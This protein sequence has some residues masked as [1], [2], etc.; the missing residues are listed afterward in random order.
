MR[1]SS[2][3]VAA[4]FGAVSAFRAVT[5]MRMFT[6]LFSE[7]STDEPHQVF[8]GN[9]PFDVS[10]ESLESIVQE[11]TKTFKSIRLIINKENGLSRGFAF[12]DYDS[13]EEADAASAALAGLQINGRSAKVDSIG[14]KADK[15]A[16]EKRERREPAARSTPQ[17]QSQH[18]VFVGNLDFSVTEEELSALVARE[19]GE[20][21][22]QAVRINKDRET[23][24]SRGFAHLD[25]TDA[26]AAS[27]VVSKL[28]GMVVADRPLKTDFA[29]KSAP[30]RRD[31]SRARPA[32]GGPSSSVFVAN[33]AWDVTPELIEEM[34][35][36]VVGPDVFQRVRLATDRETGRL[37]GFGHIDL[38]S[39]EAAQRAVRELDG[40]EVLGR[41]IRAD[42]A[43]SAEKSS[44]PRDGGARGGRGGGSR[45]GGRY[46]N[47]REESGSFGS[48]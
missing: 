23:G 36:D 1:F 3:L 46:E 20:G 22:V 40:M 32:P 15:P 28:A 31:Q 39:M 33:L 12:L 16:A 34:V 27:E 18:S 10:K 29:E 47:N 41:Q 48:W 30:V 35:N 9:L 8:I 37:R 45:G 25:C 11:H 21:R 19:V 38:V 44:G 24:R 13:K 7:V 5:P 4:S 17:G 43:T 14:Q 2:I 26:E 42:F 6:R